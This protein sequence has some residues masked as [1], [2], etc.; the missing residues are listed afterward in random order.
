MKII[1]LNNGID[2][3]MIGIGTFM[4]NPDQAEE[5]VYTALKN[6]YR[7]IDTANAYVNERGVGRGIKRSGVPRE[8]IF[9]ETKLWPA[10]YEEE[11]ME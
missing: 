7:L 2:M 5:S 3:P 10:L 6:G 8:E 1:K 11:D 9:L 4:L